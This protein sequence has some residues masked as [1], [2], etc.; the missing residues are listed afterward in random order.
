MIYNKSDKIHFIGIGGSGMSP[1]AHYL[2][3]Q[4]YHITGS[5]QRNSLST[6]ALESKGV[7]IQYGHNNTDLVSQA[8]IVVHSSA[9]SNSNTE[10]IVA[11]LNKK[12]IFRRALLLNQLF[13]DA[14]HRIAV[15]GTHGKTT[16]SG[17]ISHILLNS[18]RDPNFIIGSPLTSE[19]INYRC[20]NTDFFVIEADESDGSFLDFNATSLV[21][22]NLEEDHMSFFKTKKKLYAY[23]KKIIQNTVHFNGTVYIN[24]DDS[25]LMNLISDIKKSQLL[26]YG[27]TSDIDIRA[28]QIKFHPTGSSFTVT[29]KGHELGIITLAVFGN[30]NIYNALSAITCL[31]DHGLSFDE[32]KQ[33]LDSFTG[34]HRR[35]SCVGTKSDIVVYDDYAHHPTEIKST[36]SGLKHCLN[37]RLICIFQPHRHTRLRDFFTRFISSFSDADIVVITD[38]Y[39]AGESPIDHISAKQ[40]AQE[41]QLKHPGQINYVSSLSDIPEM[42]EPELKGGDV[43]VTMG[44]GDIS[45][46]AWDIYEN[47]L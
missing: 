22:L 18:E 47:T 10:L 9:I 14:T 23:F 35:L 6:N 4:G 1:I 17:M 19:N 30:H 44:A 12:N 41:I 15:A 40:L 42:L 38:V 2:V 37:K 32:I 29:K 27:I 34:T 39:S 8:T 36:L 11:K 28:T 26:F 24:A 45:K 25:A 31:L 33:G 7:T 13:S 46:V 16:T 5:D 3:D 43:I 20:G 21:L